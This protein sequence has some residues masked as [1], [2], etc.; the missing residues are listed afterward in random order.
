MLSELILKKNFTI[1]NYQIK[2]DSRSNLIRL[3][4]RFA[5]TDEIFAERFAADLSKHF[6]YYIDEKITELIK[7]FDF[8]I[9]CQIDEK[10]IK[11]KIANINYY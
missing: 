6:N 11:S 5:E 1:A 4:R 10:A 9:N 3:M 8:Y 2:I 7:Y